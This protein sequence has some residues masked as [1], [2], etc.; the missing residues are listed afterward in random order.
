MNNREIMDIT[1]KYHVKGTELIKWENLTKVELLA[2]L[3]HVTNAVK[4]DAKLE[5]FSIE[6]NLYF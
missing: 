4:N 2:I 5:S 3:D 1:V 6:R